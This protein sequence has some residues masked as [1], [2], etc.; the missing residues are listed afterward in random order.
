MA[1]H[2]RVR[3]STRS[4]SFTQCEIIEFAVGVKVDELDISISKKNMNS[5]VYAYFMYSIVKSVIEYFNPFT[6]WGVC[7]LLLLFEYVCIYV[8]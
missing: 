7:K 5:F 6:M 4:R 3:A 1:A 8:V 2:V